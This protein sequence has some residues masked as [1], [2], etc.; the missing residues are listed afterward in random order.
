MGSTALNCA[1][2]QHLQPKCTE[3]PKLLDLRF[4]LGCRLNLVELKQPCLR[5]S[6][7]ASVLADVI[8]IKY[9]AGKLIELLRLNCTQ[10]A[11]AD[12]GSVRDG[13]ERNP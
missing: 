2:E 12:L 7:L 10:I 4:R 11:R 9:T 6:D 5:K 8:G 1:P 3:E 13:F